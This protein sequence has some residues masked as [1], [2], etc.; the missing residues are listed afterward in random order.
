MDSGFGSNLGR[1]INGDGNTNDTGVIL[2][3]IASGGNDIGKSIA[4]D[5]SGK[6]YVTGWSS[7]GTNYDA[8]VIKI[9]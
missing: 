6:V 2:N 7:N 1:D 5:G 4:I 3:N 8:F 9:E